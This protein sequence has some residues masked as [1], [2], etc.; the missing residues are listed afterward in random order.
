[1]SYL[2]PFNKEF[3]DLL[4]KRDFYTGCVKLNIPVT[5]DLQVSKFLVDDAEVGEWTL[6]VSCHGVRLCGAPFPCVPPPALKG[7]CPAQAWL[8]VCGMGL[9][10]S[11]EV[12]QV[13]AACRPLGPWIE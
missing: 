10:S 12:N 2:G 11:S 8:G 9:E 6:Q 4:I 3:R 7:C 1:M 5:K 13:H